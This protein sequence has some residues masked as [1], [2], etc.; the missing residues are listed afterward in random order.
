MHILNA[1]YQQNTLYRQVT[2]KVEGI[3]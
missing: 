2:S 3:K 1:L